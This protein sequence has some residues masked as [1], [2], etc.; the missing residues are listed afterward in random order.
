[1]KVEEIRKISGRTHGGL[2]LIGLGLSLLFWALE[3]AAHVLVFHDGGFVKQLY[4]PEHHE[5][6][7][8]LIVVAMFVGFGLYAQWIVTA[9]KRAE[10]AAR[11]A[12]AELTQ[13]FETAA[14]GM[15]IVDKDFR[16]LRAN[17]TFLA[18]SGI[19]KEEALGKKCYEMFRGPACHTPGCPLTRILH[20]EKRVEMDA[21]KERRDGSKVPCIVTAT[22]F[23][24]PEGGLIGIVEDF[25]D[26]SD[27]KRSEHEVLQSREQLRDL[28][29][30]LQGIREKERAH[31]AREIH[32]EL[33]Q[34]LTALKMDI[35]WMR[36]KLPDR[37]ESLV[38]KTDA[39]SEL[40]DTTMKV[41]KKIS[42]ELRP[43]LLDDFG[44]S[45]AIE[46]QV[47]EFQERTGIECELTSEPQEIVLDQA[48]SIAV[49]RV[50]Q[51]ALTNITRHANATKVDVSLRERGG[52]VAME[53]RDN[54]KGINQDQV[55]DPKSFG[56]IGMRE[57]V[58]SF[59]GRLEIRGNPG[60]GTVVKADIPIDG[61]GRIHD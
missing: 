27:R 34:T 12:N 14:D 32:D 51:E 41:V 38:Q 46:W 22:P 42:A 26:I 61:K 54:G 25:K 24:D 17:E 9:R 5:I 56:L 3:S 31:I 53:V 50:A 59:G 52:Q 35:H 58:H 45:A 48:V 36:S 2:L 60:K 18:L 8:R 1:M 16:V 19:G 20:H 23:R 4:R 33:G 43:L 29:T 13:I 55:L 47:E 6:W 10:E 15:R 44:L 40:V 28:A 11:V 49:F 57:R 7:M 39:M 37:D 30:H 21:E